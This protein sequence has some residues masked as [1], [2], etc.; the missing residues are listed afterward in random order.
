[1]TDDAKLREIAEQLSR[2]VEFWAGPAGFSGEDLVSRWEALER[3]DA[4]EQFRVMVLLASV[5]VIATVGMRGNEYGRGVSGWRFWLR[6][7][8][9]EG[10]YVPESRTRL[11]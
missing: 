7:Y 6:C 5:S 8:A 9:P 2:I 10:A 1:M 3:L 4:P 11:R